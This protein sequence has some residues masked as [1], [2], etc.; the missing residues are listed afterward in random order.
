MLEIY[1]VIHSHTV[2]LQRH[3]HI[4][5]DPLTN[6]LHNKI[7]LPNTINTPAVSSNPKR[8]T[9]TMIITMTIVTSLLPVSVGSL[10]AVLVMDVMSSLDGVLVAVV[11]ISELVDGL[12]SVAVIAED[13]K[14]IVMRKCQF[15]T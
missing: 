4:D 6:T 9:A 2:F 14:G 11:T 5:D 13:R 8:I 7:Y 15:S 12:I 1:M 3:T 10:V